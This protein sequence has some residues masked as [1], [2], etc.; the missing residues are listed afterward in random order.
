MNSSV[1][2]I[3]VVTLAVVLAAGC[4]SGPRP[5]SLPSVD[6]QTLLAGEAFPGAISQ[7]LPAAE[8]VF[9]LSPDMV[10]FL[11][12]NVSGKTDERAFA[13]LI[14]AMETFGIRQLIYDNQTRT[15]SQ[16]FE[17]RHGNCLSF[18][19]MFLVMARQVGLR[20]KFQEVRI[21]PEWIKQGEMQVLRRHVNVYVRLT[22][23]GKSLDGKGDRVVDFD[24]EGGP[25]ASTETIISDH[26][27]L[28]HFYNNWAVDALDAG[29]MDLAF[30]YAR[31]AIV[32]G[33]AD[34]SPAWGLIGVLYRRAERLDLAEAAQLRA[35]QAEPSDEVAMSNLQR[36]YAS[37]GRDELADYYRAQ[38]IGHRL[39]NPYYRMEKAREAY[40]DKD[41]RSA[42]THLR[43][44]IAL[45]DDE[46]EFYFL[47]RDSYYQMGD[48]PKARQYHAKAHKVLDAQ[49]GREGTPRRIKPKGGT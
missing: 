8:D 29:D 37:Q 35:L 25:S 38:V 22:G 26:R 17:D 48:I 6:D 15:A 4:S 44:A 2:K 45:K 3:F 47:L 10:S 16:T 40:Q 39:K 34:F 11:D 36:L 19:N 41:Y 9:G 33:D 32:D 14:T 18:T 46:S 49:G 24:D 42:V 21:S 27:A 30:A 31:K 12:E 23:K 20:A 43:K 5:G 1:K 7:S 28:A 13:D